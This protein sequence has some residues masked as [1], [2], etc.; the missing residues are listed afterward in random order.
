MPDALKLWRNARLATCDES[1]RLIERGALLTRGGLIE[2]VGEESALPAAA[3]AL[4]QVHDLAGAWVTPG[5]IDCH[6]HLVFAGNR[7][8]EY[9]ERLRGRSYEEIARA[10]GGILATMR[11]VRAASESQLFEESAPRL[12]AL[13]AEGVTTIEI[14]SGYGLTLED[15]AKMLRVARELGRAFPVTVRT[16]L[17]AAHTVPPEYH[18]RPDAYLDT[19]AREWLPELNARGLIDAVDVFCDRVAFSVAQ[20]ERLFAAARALG[21][22]VKM[23]A[24]QLANLGGTLMAAAH[25]A[26]SC[27]HLEYADAAEAA[28]LGRSG[29]VAV[30]LP[31]AYYCLGGGRQP[32]LA[33][34]RSARAALAI[35]SDCN[36]GSAPGASLLLAMSMATR[37]F[38][39][40]AD[41]ALLGV[42]RHAAQAL[43]L[44]A[45]GG[46][47]SAGHAADFVVWNIGSPAELSYWIGFNP[48]RTVVRAAE[49]LPWPNTTP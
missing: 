46:A 32:P 22:P 26:L 42:T 44:G 6:T 34:L 35:A 41:E 4:A 28:A 38:G 14:K 17:L 25:G 27:D 9:A 3:G 19:V 24:E 2:W 11:A 33:A 47:L 45:R 39:L 16:T 37:L 31:V 8:G 18:G 30:L 12:A 23:H 48:R 5:L 15:E 20:A 36:P 43:G 1:Q 49:V 13:L 7:A 21:L 10:G 40:T 29:T